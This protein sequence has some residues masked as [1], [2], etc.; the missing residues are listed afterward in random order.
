VAEP[1]AVNASPLIYPASA[2][3]LDSLQHIA[4]IVVVP[5]SVTGEIQQRGPTDVT[6]QALQNTSRMG[7]LTPGHRGHYQRF[8][9]Q[10]LCSSLGIPVRG[11]LGLLFTAKRRG[12][13]PEDRPVL[14]RLRHAGM[15]L[16]DRVM[17][18]ALS[19]VGE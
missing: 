10:A 11:A 5:V 14:E 18:Q 2:G 9:R 1:P 8:G 16:S 3:L 13:I 7:I 15:Y 12:R 6:A 17:S 19:P 4:D